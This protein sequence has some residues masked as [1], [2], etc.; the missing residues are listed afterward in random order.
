MGNDIDGEHAPL[1]G[2]EVYGTTQWTTLKQYL[3]T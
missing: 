3:K 2:Y 1:F